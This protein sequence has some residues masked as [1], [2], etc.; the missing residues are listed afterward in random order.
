MCE[1]GRGGGRVGDFLLCGRRHVPTVRSGLAPGFQAGLVG[2]SA[3]QAT[4]RSPRSPPSASPHSAPDAAARSG[5]LG[6]G[7]SAAATR[8]SCSCTG[9][10][11]AHSC[12]VRT[13]ERCRCDRRR[14]GALAM[15]SCRSSLVKNW[16]SIRSC[17]KFEIKYNLCL[18]LK[19]DYTRT[20]NLVLKYSISTK[21]TKIRALSVW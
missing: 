16:R 18:P 8:S 19:K 20:N 12:P 3:S 9:H 2:A 5:A 1:G 7:T 15:V 17:S 14:S 11:K 21:L 13:A 4:P 10:T 6:A